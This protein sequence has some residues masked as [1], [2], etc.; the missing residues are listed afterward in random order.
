MGDC[1]DLAGFQR[2]LS[3]QYT[4]LRDL[5]ATENYPVYAIEHGLSADERASAR[6]LLNAQLESSMRADRAHSL[7][8]IAA[9]AEIGYR[10]DGTEYWESFASAFPRWPLYGNRNQIRNWYQRFAK[11]FG[12]LTPSGPWARQFPIIAWPITQAI[13]P[14]YLQ[15]HF[16]DHLYELRHALAHSGELTL[17]EIG[18]LLSDRYFGGSSRF[19]G[20]LQ[21]KALTARIVMA[22]GLEDVADTISPIEH[23]TLSRIV[24]DF[25]KLGSSGS[26]LREARRVL[27]DARFVNSFKQGFKP[28]AANRASR[29]TAKIDRVD[30]P[31]LAARPTGDQSWYVDLSIPD[32]ATPLRQAGLSQHELERAQMRFRVLGEANPWIPGR[33]LFSYTGQ[34][35]EPLQ[36]YPTTDRQIFEF[37]RPLAKAEAVLRERLTF[38]VQPLRLL[39]IRTDGSAYEIAGRHVRAG[40]RRE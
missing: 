23:A 21:Q 31:M 39:K 8:W 4:R 26:R 15:R 11:D 25:D 24:R 10:Y 17:D 35:S 22:L 20:F 14:R 27:R 40:Q 2:R 37:D 18:D 32:L 5:R 3:E 12:G 34:S 19:E 33:A 29:D 16:A 6:A 30:R 36:A 13:L 38:P 1:L 28:S 7:V 9:A